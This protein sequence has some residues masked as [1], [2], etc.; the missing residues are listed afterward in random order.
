MSTSIPYR[1]NVEGHVPASGVGSAPSSTLLHHQTGTQPPDLRQAL[2][3]GDTQIDTFTYQVSDGAGGTDTATV[4][5][6][7]TGSNDGPVA[8]ADS[9][10]TAEDAAI[11]IDVLANDFDVD[12]G[13]SFEVTSFD[14]T[15]ASGASVTQNPDG[16][17]SY[18]PSGSEALTALDD[19]ETA[20][21]TFTYT[22]TD[23][24]GASRT[25]T[26]TVLVTGTGGS[27]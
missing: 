21:D 20:T 13:S 26:V 7:I 18:D 1:G 5:V 4:T 27:D 16:T 8:V 6:T 17:F 24:H 2:A 22:I 23:E 9:G 12:S 14:G 11:T 25:A 15:S 3:V 19:G 10:T